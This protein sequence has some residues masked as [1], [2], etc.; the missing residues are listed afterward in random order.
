MKISPAKAE[1]FLGKPDGA[2]SA[3]LIYGPDGGLVRE[4]AKALVKTITG[5]TDD[6]FLVSEL[7][8]AR[9]KDDPT[10][11]MDEAT[12]MSMTG[13]RRA[14]WL[15]ES[16]EA[17]VPQFESLFAVESLESLVVI[18]AS[19]LG[20]RSKLRK[21]FETSKKAA[22]IACYL[23]DERAL[24]EV[25]S[26][27][28]REK[29]MTV[30][31]DALAWLKSHLGN[32]RSVTRAELEKICLFKGDSGE[33][34]ME[35]A[36]LCVGDSTE[37]TLDDLA[38][39]VGR[40]DL[41]ETGRLFD[42]AIYEGANAVGILR[43]LIRHFTRLHLAGGIVAEGK[44]ADQ[45]MKSLKPPVFFKQTGAFEAQMRVWPVSRGETALA[46]LSE[47][48]SISKSSGMPAEVYCRQMLMRLAVMAKSA[49]R[50][51]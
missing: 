47:A 39:A 30:N 37:A 35:D 25:I 51:R 31:R 41:A 20:P 4:R 38:F 32:D 50:R 5:S 17:L 29:G 33:V 16:S 49:N 10:C 8:S 27:V 1:Q 43:V 28:F 2:V 22:A 46:M 19:N 13:G 14:I 18:E 12:A 3:V 11:L 48:E 40:G 24:G 15:R 23:D 34:S 45:A 9:L 6:P 7:D 21:M 36:Q 44:S 42:R 26:G